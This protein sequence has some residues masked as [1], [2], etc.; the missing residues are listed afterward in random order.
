MPS[1]I[2]PDQ[3]RKTKNMTTLSIR[4]S[5]DRARPRAARSINTLPFWRG[6]LLIPLACVCSTLSPQA[7]AVCQEGCD[8]NLGSTYLGDN[9]LVSNITGF[10][11]T[12]NGALALYSNTYGSNN[13]ATGNLTLNY[14]TTGSLNAATGHQALYSNTTGTDNTA[15]GA[16]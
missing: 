12:T 11:N 10:N 7:W 5:V 4:N 14:N 8:L 13:T 9:A 1:K 6:L 3:D 16:K 2:Q 15:N